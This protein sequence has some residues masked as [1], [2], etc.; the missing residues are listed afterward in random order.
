MQVRIPVWTVPSFRRSHVTVSTHS[1]VYRS[2]TQGLVLEM[3]GKTAVA[4][5]R[6]IHTLTIPRQEKRRPGGNSMA[7]PPTLGIV[8]YVSAGD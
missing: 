3:I 1:Q 5:A 4:C 6:G 7:V 2:C 8:S